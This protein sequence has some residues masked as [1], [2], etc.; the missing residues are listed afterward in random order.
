MRNRL[1]QIAL[2]L[3][4]LVLVVQVVLVAPSQIRDAEQKAALLP[5]PAINA[6]NDV[7]QSATGLHMIETHEGG[8][9]WELWS[10]KARSLKV[11]ELLEL[12]VV[13]AIFFADSGVTFTVNGRAGTVHEKTKS[14]HVEGDVVTK[15]SN[16]YIFRTQSVDYDSAS[17]VMRSPHPVEMV[18]PKDASGQALHLTGVGMEA[19]LDNNSMDILRDVRSTKNLDNGKKANIKSQRARFSAADRTA[20]FF[21]DVV[22]DVDNMRITG[23]QATFEYDKDRDVLKSVVFT[24]GARVSDSDKWATAQ[25]VRVDF[26]KDRFIFKGAP[27]VVQNNDE[28]RGEEI[29]LLDGGKRVQVKNARAKVDEKRLE[30]QN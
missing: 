29:I 4:F 13:K 19:H 16:G 18:G 20:Q 11:K 12:D 27:R 25:N 30:K 22:L 8:K 21:G 10:D 3:A 5:A 14:L 17:K 7:D 6:G 23:P 2:S 28:L 9:E 1:I 15:S 24:G 26:E